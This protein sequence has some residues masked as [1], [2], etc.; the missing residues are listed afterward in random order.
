M[1]AE[2]DGEAPRFAMLAILRE[3]DLEPLQAN[4]ELAATRR[5]HADYYATT[6]GTME[7]GLPEAQQAALLIQLEHRT[8]KTVHVP[9]SSGA[10][11]QM[12]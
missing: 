12:G 8:D 3:Y 7:T 10:G 4:G 5:R 11:V 9:G 6:A 1:N 2:T